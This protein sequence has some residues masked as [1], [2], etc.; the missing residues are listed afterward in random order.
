MDDHPRL[1]HAAAPGHGPI[2]ALHW[3]GRTRCDVG[4]GPGRGPLRLTWHR[5]GTP[6]RHR[7]RRAEALEARGSSPN[8][9]VDIVA[10]SGST[11]VLRSEGV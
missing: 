11:S 5:P 6:Q 1:A 2:Q 7:Q 10:S 3:S 8:N 4:K 9:L